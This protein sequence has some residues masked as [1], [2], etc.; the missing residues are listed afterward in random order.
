M[1]VSD[2]VDE[3]SDGVGEALLLSQGRE[4][5]HHGGVDEAALVGAGVGDPLLEGGNSLVDGIGVGLEVGVVLL[6]A[7][8]VEVGSVNE[9]PARLPG[10]A[11]CLD[12][13]GE[14]RA[15]HKWIVTLKVCHGGV[16]AAVH[17]QEGVGF[18]ESNLS[19]AG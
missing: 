1:D 2:V 10:A 11:L 19:L 18:G 15:F 4:L 17:L 8:L 14:G 12:L 6:A 5:L 9:V 13:V 16:R 3:E 7:S